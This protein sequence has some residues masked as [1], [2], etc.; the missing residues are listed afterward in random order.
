MTTPRPLLRLV[1]GLPLV[2][3]TLLL[4]GALAPLMA[5]DQE[6]LPGSYTEVHHWIPAWT[7]VQPD[8]MRIRHPGFWLVTRSGTPPADAPAVVGEA[9]AS[10]TTVT[11]AAD[12]GSSVV[13]VGCATPA[14]MVCAPACEP[15]V[16]V[17]CAPLPAA[18]GCWR[19]SAW[20]WH[21]PSCFRGSVA[22]HGHGGAGE[23]HGGGEHGGGGWLPRLALLPLA[24]LALLGHLHR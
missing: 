19:G 20:G 10:T 15:V 5:E 14:P 21:D 18:R 2:T 17:P 13:E 4:A 24:P 9:P 12:Q 8:G 11:V 16:V 7:E 1:Q 23:W 22:E 6:D 3:A